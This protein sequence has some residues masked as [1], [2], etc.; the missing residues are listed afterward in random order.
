M[1]KVLINAQTVH[2]EFQV[3]GYPTNQELTV[4]PAR[5]RY[6]TRVE[7]V[8]RSYYPLLLRLLRSGGALLCMRYQRIETRVAVQW[9]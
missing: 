8:A 2:V 5:G 9:F 7:S 4:Y 1:G 3:S 6:S